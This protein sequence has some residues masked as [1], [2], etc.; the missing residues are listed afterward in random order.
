MLSMKSDTEY[1]ID[2]RIL[3]LLDAIFSTGD[4]KT[5]ETAIKIANFEDDI[6]LKEIMHFVGGN[7]YMEI[8]DNKACSLWRKDDK[9]LYFEDI[10]AY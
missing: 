8:G 3:L 7:E 5:K 9:S 10:W 6:V 1:F 4:G 2:K